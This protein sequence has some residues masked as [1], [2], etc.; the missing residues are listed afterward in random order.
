M[1]DAKKVDRLDQS[2]HTIAQLPALNHGEIMTIVLQ[3]KLSRDERLAIYAALSARGTQRLRLEYLSDARAYEIAGEVR[4][5]ALIWM[6]DHGDD[7]DDA[8]ARRIRSLR[9]V[10]DEGEEPVPIPGDEW[11]FA[12]ALDAYD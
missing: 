2:L 10:V 12:E 4:D 6:R 5:A 9:G 1:L 7:A 3:L 8:L 11:R